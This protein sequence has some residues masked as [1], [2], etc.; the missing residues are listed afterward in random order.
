MGQDHDG[1]DRYQR[2]YLHHQAAKAE[3]LREIML[4]CHSDRLFAPEGVAADVLARVVAAAD[5]APSSCD[6]HAVRVRV[7]RERD[8]KARLGGLLVGGVGWVHRA[9]AILLLHA[10]PAAYKAPGELAF[11]PFLDTGFAADR[12]LLAAETEGLKHC[13]VNPAIREADREHFQKSFEIELLGGAVALG[14]P[15]P[16]EWVLETS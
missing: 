14:W 2:A 5:T 7:V 8:A 3:V 10:D 9:P 15:P 12:M 16:P 11:M 1:I 6:R 4:R 13:F